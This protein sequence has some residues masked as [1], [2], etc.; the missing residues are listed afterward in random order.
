M[1]NTKCM[2]YTFIN[3]KTYYKLY[4]IKTKGFHLFISEDKNKIIFKHYACINNYNYN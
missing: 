4:L 2:N 3:Q 1:C